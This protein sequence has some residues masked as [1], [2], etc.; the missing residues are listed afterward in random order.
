VAPAT[1]R[2]ISLL[3]ADHKTSRKVLTVAVELVFHQ[4]IKLS[5]L[6][7]GSSRSQCQ[8]KERAGK[9]RGERGGTAALEKADSIRASRSWTNP[10]GEEEERCLC[11]DKYVGTAVAT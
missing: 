7:E 3:C 8:H 9:R 1:G 4:L 11:E 6:G 5:W 10:W 2:S